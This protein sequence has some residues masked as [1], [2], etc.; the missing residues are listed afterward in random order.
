MLED[1]GVHPEAENLVKKDEIENLIVDAVHQNDFAH[2]IYNLERKLV[3]Q[4][5]CTALYVK[6]AIDNEGLL[7]PIFTVLLDT[8][9]KKAR[10]ET[11]DS[12]CHVAIAYGT[13]PIVLIG[14]KRIDV[15]DIE[16]CCYFK[17][18]AS[19]ER[20]LEYDDTSL[21]TKNA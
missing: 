13:S 21:W 19:H 1:Y 12:A 16:L 17:G 14:C 2:F 7:P 11:I 9:D 6:N 10:W 18:I 8:L 5:S 3:F 15:E 4:P 20:F